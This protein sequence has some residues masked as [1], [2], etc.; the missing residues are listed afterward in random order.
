MKKSAQVF[1]VIPILLFFLL[2]S[3]SCK[4]EEK[5][6]CETVSIHG[7]SIKVCCSADNCYYE[8]NG[9]RYNCDGTDCNDAAQR[10]AN[11]ILSGGGKS[12]P[13]SEEMR[14]EVINLLLDRR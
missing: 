10:L 11:D 12:L 5:F 14:S 2:S 7:E 13:V 4:K 3:D 1:W 9:K 8:W 6:E